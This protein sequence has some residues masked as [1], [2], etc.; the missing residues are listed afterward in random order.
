MEGKGDG[1]TVRRSRV[2][3]LEK[4]GTESCRLWRERKC[5][6]RLG[7]ACELTENHGEVAKD[8][9]TVR[10]DGAVE[11]VGLPELVRRGVA[12]KKER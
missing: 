10:L 1:F 6:S 8:G 5:V 3:E 2:E 7:F 4:V 11:L 9:S 12:V